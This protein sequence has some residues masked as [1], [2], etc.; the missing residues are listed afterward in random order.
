M[1]TFY[2][3][4]YKHIM[5]HLNTHEN[6]NTNHV[7]HIVCMWPWA[8]TVWKPLKSPK[9]ACATTNRCF[10]LCPDQPWLPARFP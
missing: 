6:Q 9:L 5:N 2:I 4:I 3:Y 7:F 8:F 1:I 10:L